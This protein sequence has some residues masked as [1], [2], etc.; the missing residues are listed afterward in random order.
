M[1]CITKKY[2]FTSVL[3]CILTAT[4]FS[5]A[6]NQADSSLNKIISASSSGNVK[7]TAGASLSITG[8]GRIHFIQA[9]FYSGM[10]CSTLQ[11]VASV[12]DNYNGAGFSNETVNLT[13]ASL[14]NLAVSQNVD[15]SQ[16]TCMK[17]FL[18]GST[19]SSNGITCQTFDDMSCANSECISSQSKSVSWAN[20]PS[21]CESKHVY[22]TNEGNNR[23]R[24]CDIGNGGALTCSDTATTGVDEPHGIYLNNGH[25]YIANEGASSVSVCDINKDTGALSSCNS[26]AISGATFTVGNTINQGYLYQAAYIGN[27]M[28]RCSVTAN[29]GAISGCIKIDTGNFWGVSI[30]QPSNS[31][32]AYSYISDY[33]DSEIKKCTVSASGAFSSCVTSNTNISGPGGVLAYNGYLYVANYDGDTVAKCTINSSN[34]T[35]SSCTTYSGF[36]GPNSIGIYNG[37]AYIANYDND[38]V[39]KCTV[40]VDGALS[41]CIST[42]SGFNDPAFVA[43]Y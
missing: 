15:T 20:N 10:S 38:T 9:F 26:T 16:T 25:A 35:L 43:I 37:Y 31:S 3:C 2:F 4:T 39:S 22:I 18:T 33:T 13:A 21:P 34:G 8:S 14:Y 41:S 32:S 12:I 40:G 17:L 1:F 36:N 19:T 30:S 11:G 29:G 24:T 5:Y 6:R 42:G 7:A 27:D 23:V 28:Y